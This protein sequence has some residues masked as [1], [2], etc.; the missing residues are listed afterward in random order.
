MDTVVSGVCRRVNLGIKHREWWNSSHSV[1][2]IMWGGV[3]TENNPGSNGIGYYHDIEH[4]SLAML[5][6]VWQ[7]CSQTVTCQLTLRGGTQPWL[8]WQ[9]MGLHVWL[10]SPKTGTCFLCVAPFLAGVKCPS[11]PPFRGEGT[12]PTILSLCATPLSPPQW[13]PASWPFPQFSKTS[14]PNRNLGTH[15]F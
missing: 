4:P 1:I 8:G 10:A 7:N 6:V 3:L 2:R 14:E 12:V 5:N 9:S 11:R 15:F 13:K